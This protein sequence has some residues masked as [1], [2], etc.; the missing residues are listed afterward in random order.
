MQAAIEVTQSKEDDQGTE[1][2]AFDY[3][4]LTAINTCPRWGL[5]RYDQHRRMPGT[6]RNLPLEMGSLAH[7]CFAAIRYFELLE[8]GPSVYRDT[9]DHRAVAEKGEQLFGRDRLAEIVKLHGADEDLRRRLNS[10]AIYVANMYGYYDDPSDRRR[11]LSNLEASLSSYIDRTQ[12]GQRLPIIRP[13]IGI[14][15]SFDITITFKEEEAAQDV[16]E[17]AQSRSEQGATRKVRYVGLIDG[18]VHPHNDPSSIQ[19][20]ENKTASRLNHSWEDSFLTSH[21]VTGY[22]VAASQLTRIPV[23][24]CI[25][26][27]MMVPLPRTYDLEGIA[28]LPVSRD[29][30]RIREWIKWVYDT[31]QVW[32][33]WKDDPL[34][35]PEFTHS[36][37]RYFRSCSFIPLCAMAD[38]EDRALN[39][40]Q[41]VVDKWDP[42]DQ[43]ET[44]NE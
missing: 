29:I 4:K 41:M 13:F 35:A 20:E 39:F 11:T 27:G 18:L 31:V 34:N 43:E 23:T 1:I 25:V 14:E 44:S 24:E 42:L 40:S 36:C 6:G 2:P 19:C 32:D 12:L 16:A 38:P 30:W 37:N 17:H 7:K 26:R 10:V 28:N 3:T 5:I 15:N 22:C 21:Q 8:Y 9:Y 33:K